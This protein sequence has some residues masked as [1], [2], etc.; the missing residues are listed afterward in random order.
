MDYSWD[1]FTFGIILFRT[2]IGA[3]FPNYFSDRISFLVPNNK[4][5]SIRIHQIH[6]IPRA[7]GIRTDMI[8]LLSKRVH[9]HPTHVGR[10]VHSGAKVVQVQPHSCQAFLTAELIRLL[11]RFLCCKILAIRAVCVFGEDC[12]RCWRAV[13]MIRQSGRLHNARVVDEHVHC[14]GGQP[15]DSLRAIR[16]T[17]LLQDV[18]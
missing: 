16:C 12:A 7:I 11:I 3:N 5:L 13:I 4:H 1:I 14:S 2:R 17:L 10:G 8:V 15:D 18:A 9:G 6:R